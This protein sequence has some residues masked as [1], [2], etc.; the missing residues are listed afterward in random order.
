MRAFLLRVVRLSTY[1][2]LT[3]PLMPIQAILLSLAPARAAGFARWYHGLCWRVLGFRVEVKGAVSERRP[4]LFVA[5]HVSYLDITIF[6]GLIKGSFIAKA[7]V[8]GWPLFGR[9]ARLQRTVFVE[10]RRGQTA[11]SRD[12]IAERLAG[13]DNLIL[14]PEGTSGD[15]N[16]VLPFRSGLFGAAAIEVGGAPLAVQP[17]SIAY[18]RLN[19]MPMGRFFR[20]FFAWYGD[21][22]MAPHLWTLLGLGTLTAA[23]EFHP[24]VTLAELGSRKALAEHCRRVIAAGM[25]AALSGRETSAEPVRQPA[26]APEIVAAVPPPARLR[27]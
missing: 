17:V 2:T 21:M 4:T 1:L 25:A 7:E 16:R 26:L 18:V 13:R 20:P 12:E 15:G 8:A 5:N 9:L 24:V 11:K 6:G 10:R 23:V 27:A 22:S 19:G 14:F 3:L